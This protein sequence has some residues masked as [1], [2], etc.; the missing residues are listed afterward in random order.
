[1]VAAVGEF[2]PVWFDPS[3]TSIGRRAMT[4]TVQAEARADVR[5]TS[6]VRGGRH[7]LRW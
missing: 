3:V 2:D 6:K 4:A 1:M 7:E 5:H